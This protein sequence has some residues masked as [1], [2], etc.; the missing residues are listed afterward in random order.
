[1]SEAA[2]C[3]SC[4]ADLSG[5]LVPVSRDECCDKCDADVRVCLNCIHYD[6]GVYNEC[7][8]PQAERVVEKDRRN[9]CD[10]FKLGPN[11]S[12]SASGPSKEDTLKQLDDLFKK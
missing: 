1:M 3:H 4:S 9:F 10:Y 8:E 11:K 6:P 7:H 5:V 12:A 2:K